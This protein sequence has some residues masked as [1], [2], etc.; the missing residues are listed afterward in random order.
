MKNEA[1]KN[2]TEAEKNHPCII[3]STWENMLKNE[4]EVS[5]NYLMQRNNESK[6]ELFTHKDY[7][8]KPRYVTYGD[9]CNCSF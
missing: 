2:L 9:K 3:H 5:V 1:K 8:S 4:H 7:S 6:Q